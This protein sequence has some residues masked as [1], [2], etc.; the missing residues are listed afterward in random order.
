[1]K[2]YTYTH[3]QQTRIGAE[4]DGHLVDLTAAFG[5]TDMT[6]FIRQYDQLPVAETVA[7]ATDLTDFQ[8]V[9]LQIPLRPGMVWCSGLNYKSH[10]LENPNAKFLSEPRFFA[11]TPNTYIGPGQPIRHP[12]E[13]FQV[14]FEVE[15]A[16]VFGKTARRLTSGNAMEHVFGYTILH[17]VGA[18]YIQFKDNNEMMGKN[19]DT[20]CPIGPCIVTADEIPHP[21]K[22][23]IRLAINGETQQDGTN[24]DWCFTLPH[25]LEWLTMAVTLAPGDVVS[26][27]TCSGIGYFQKPPRFLHPGD[28]VTLEIPEIGT[29]SNPVVADPYSLGSG[30]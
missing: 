27:G 9:A 18:R 26:T 24:E 17:D 4:K 10:I 6:D 2:L 30:A 13:R 20:F 15:F 7:S 29:L 23:R 16:V 1:M 22:C 21:E 25:L 5:I 28:V 12:G 11:K 3:N 14:D 19:F 8:D